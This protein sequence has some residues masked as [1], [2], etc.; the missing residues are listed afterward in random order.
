MNCHSSNIRRSI[1]TLAPYFV[2]QALEAAVEPIRS[3]DLIEALLE[4]T[5]V[6]ERPCRV[7]L[8]AEHYILNNGLRNAQLARKRGLSLADTFRLGQ[9]DGAAGRGG[10]AR[11]GRALA[12]RQRRRAGVGG[13]GVG[14]VGR[15][16]PRVGAGSGLERLEREFV[17]G[18]Q[19]YLEAQ[20]VR[21]DVTANAAH[22]ERDGGVGR[23]AAVQAWVEHE[24][25]AALRQRGQRAGANVA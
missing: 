13:V 6:A 1:K 4:P 11:R 14:A 12:Q 19:C 18:C 25:L 2:A 15:D 16:A 22:G 23:G 20:R 7:L 21:K 5:V 17:V 10:G 9:P 8:V 24:V 3:E